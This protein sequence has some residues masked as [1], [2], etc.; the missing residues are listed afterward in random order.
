V[1]ALRV[2]GWLLTTGLCSKCGPGNTSL[3]TAL[4]SSGR[5]L[6]LDHAG[7]SIPLD[8]SL[9]RKASDGKRRLTMDFSTPIE[10]LYIED[11][12]VKVGACARGSLQQ[13]SYWKPWLSPRRMREPESAPGGCTLR[14]PL[15]SHTCILPACVRVVLPEGRRPSRR[16]LRAPPS[17]H[18]C[19]RPACVQV[20]L[21]E[22]SSAIE[23]HP[24]NPSVELSSDLKFTYLDIAG[25]P[26]VRPRGG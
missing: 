15:S 10:G 18:T 9:F 5:T 7:Y 1:F 6:D 20:V 8:G 21:P 17:S 4:T 14:T 22:G 3:A 12:T 23:A 13:Y 2:R 19:I 25:R 11:L 26:V 16:T 24:P